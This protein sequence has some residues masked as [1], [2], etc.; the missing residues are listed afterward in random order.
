MA[1]STEAPGTAAYMPWTTF[2]NT[3]DVFA[4]NLPNRI[5]RSVF[6]GQ[7]GGTQNQLIQGFRFLGLINDTGQPTEAMQAVAV[8]DKDARKAALKKTIEQKYAALFALNLMK[9]T[10]SELAEKMTEAY[11]VSGDTRLK[12]TRFFLSAASYIDVPVSPLLLRDKSKPVG[13]GGGLRKKRQAR[14]QDPAPATNTP[15]A[16]PTPPPQ[17]GGTARSIALKSG[18]TLTISATLDLFSLNAGDRTFVFELIDKLDDYV[19]QNPPADDDV[20]DDEE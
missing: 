13:N 8:E 20:D 19:K 12:A 10:P 9:T 3:L 16:N 14:R 1:D 7:S 2:F 15:P 11:N 6:P 4:K 18:G 5:D 17:A